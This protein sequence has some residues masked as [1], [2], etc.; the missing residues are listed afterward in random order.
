M[1]I[2]SGSAPAN[3]VPN[4]ISDE[5]RRYLA[6]TE[7]GMSIRAL[8]RDAGCHASTILRQVRRFESRRED[9]LI[10]L[11]LIR[12]GSAGVAK[13]GVRP[14]TQDGDIMNTGVNL[15]TNDITDDTT[16]RQEAPR[17]LR[18][19]NEPGACLAIAKDMEK[20]VVVRDTDDGQTLRTAV[21]DRQIAEAMALKDW[22]TL[23]N[24]GRIARYRITNAGR[25][26]LKRF[27]AEDEAKSLGFQENA[28]PFHA[29]HSD[30]Q[31]KKDNADLGKRRR[32]R[33]KVVENP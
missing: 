24:D 5:V 7:E 17:I 6:H 28:Q 1:H 23:S 29:Q 12:L 2:V 22:I 21:I 15:Q 26:A 18:R 10:D 19:L 25:N 20:A 33:Y 8:A 4:W 27:L 30:M 16:L 3:I 14:H 9:L 11:A 13:A 32:G 31:E